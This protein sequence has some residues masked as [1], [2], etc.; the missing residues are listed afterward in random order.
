MSLEPFTDDDPIFRRESVLRDT[1]TPETLVERDREL[2]EFQNALKPVVK[3]EVPKNIFLY[4]QTGVGKSIATEMVLDR[5]KQDQE[6]F[7]DLNVEVTYVLCKN[8]TSSYQVTVEL[9]NTFREPENQISGTGHSHG[10]VLAKLWQHIN[11]IDA[12]HLL[13]VLDEIDSVG[14]DDDIL[15]QLPR[16]N[17]NG[18]VDPNNVKLGVIGISNDFTFRDQ[19]DARVQD[20]LAEDEIHFPPY[21]SNQLRT[22]LHDRAGNAFVDGALADDVIPLCAAFAGQETGSARQALKLLYKSGDL[23]RSEDVSMVEERHVRAA[24]DL[25]EAGK[26]KDELEALPSQSHLTLF[27]MLRMADKGLLPARSTDIYD[28]Y[29]RAARA[30]DADVKSIRTIRSRLS[31]LL[32]KGFLKK[33]QRNEGLNGGSFFLYELDIR[34]ELIREVLQEDDRTKQLFSEGSKQSR[35][36]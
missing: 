29:D 5:L 9:V 13:I 4:G 3:G 17:A 15:Y 12:T 6:N 26:A 10:A 36:R 33:T 20:S 7:D 25:V 19:L 23:A 16:A 30:I 32:M 34:E 24:Q 11:D 8:L 31:Q 18:K 2:R 28:Y 21:D 1:Y 14:T 27:A 22:I 35:I